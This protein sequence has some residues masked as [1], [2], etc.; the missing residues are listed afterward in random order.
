MPNGPHERSRYA[1]KQNSPHRPPSAQLEPCPPPAPDRRRRG[2]VVPFDGHRQANI[3]LAHTRRA[4]TAP[5]AHCAAQTVCAHAHPPSLSRSFLPGDGARRKHAR[6]VVV[7]PSR[8]FPDG[9][10]VFRLLPERDYGNGSDRVGH[11]HRR[12]PVV[13]NHEHASRD[14]PHATWT[15]HRS[16]FG[17]EFELRVSFF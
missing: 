3:T 13:F 7:Q 5:R 6:A 16:R 2:D 4:R 1:E 10:D 17:L 8:Q 15:A 9:N 11:F 12:D 14:P